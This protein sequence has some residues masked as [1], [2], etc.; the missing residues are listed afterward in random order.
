MSFSG[1]CWPHAHESFRV[2]KFAGGLP[3]LD[4]VRG[5]SENIGVM[6]R[7]RGPDCPDTRRLG[8]NSAQLIVEVLPIAESTVTRRSV[9]RSVARSVVLR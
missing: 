4:T 1:R 5:R 3:V 9:A 7:I 6:A 8:A 2:P